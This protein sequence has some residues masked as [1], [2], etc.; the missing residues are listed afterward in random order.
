MR[1]DRA[2]T[3]IVTDRLT[4]RRS[5]PADAEAISAYRSLPEVHEHQGWGSTDPDHV[6]DEIVEMLGRAPGDPG[7]W[8]QFSVITNA[9]G[10]LVGDVGLSPADGEPGVIKVGYT[11]APEHQGHG[12][13]TEAVRAL[14]GYA[15][16]T[17]DVRVVRA[18]A[19]E[20]NLP[21]TSVM[22][23]AGLAHVET[24]D[25]EEDGQIW[26][27]VRYERRRDA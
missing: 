5:E 8:V 15:F 9:D 16:D 14:V 27:I 22:R 10:H 20:R 1:P 13:A 25:E 2:F 17:L 26:R 6:R 3:P 23:K 18:Y 24:W 19:E 11:I 4:L 12:Y 7:G 21:S